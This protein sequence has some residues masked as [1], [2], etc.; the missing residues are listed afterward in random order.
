MITTDK[1]ECFRFDRHLETVGQRCRGG[2]RRFEQTVRPVVVARRSVNTGAGRRRMSIGRV[3]TL[4]VGHFGLVQRRL[5]GVAQKVPLSIQHGQV[6]LTAAA[7]GP[8]QAE[9]TD[10]QR[11]GVVVSE[12]QVG[13]GR[14][15]LQ[16][17]TADRRR[18]RRRS[19]SRR[20]RR[21][22]YF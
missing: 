4:R 8:T 6:A 17:A 11:F 9:R 14:S 20:R 13:T 15:S 1:P 3:R 10:G 22:S 2:V 12:T 18:R 16:Q 19:S 21:R 5:D 7:A